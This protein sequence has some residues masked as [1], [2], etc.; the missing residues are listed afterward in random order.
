MMDLINSGVVKAIS[1]IRLFPYSD[2]PSALRFMR[3]AN[4]IGKIIISN[5]EY[6]ELDPMVPVRPAS[7]QFKLRDDVSYLIIGGL[8]GLCGSLAID[9]ARNGARHLIIMSRS[10]YEDPR[11][12]AALKDINAHGCTAQTVRGDVSK[13]EDVRRAFRG[14]SKPVAGVVQGAMVLRDKPFEM[15]SHEEYRTAITPKVAGTWNLHNVALEMGLTLDFFTMLSSISGLI[16]QPAQANYAAANVFLDNFA[17][18]RRGLGLK[19]NSVDLGAIDDIGY[20]AEHSE[21]IAGLDTSAWTPINESLFQ[22]IVQYSIMQQEDMPINSKSF[23]Q[24]ITSIAVPQASSSRLLVD[25]RFSSLL[26]GAAVGAGAGPD[27]TGLNH[28][29]QALLVMIKGGADIV[30]ALPLAVEVANKQFMTS[31]RLD[32]PLEPGKPLSAYGLDSLAAVEFRN[33]SRA[34]LGAELTTLEVTSA[35]SL[36]SLAEKIV[37]KLHAAN[38]AA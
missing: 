31:L 20:M 6:I 10:N 32:E 2:I 21:L 17:Y 1:P 35:P 38:A 23:S 22:N 15:M 28:E 4:H 5:K 8:K 34:Q 18:Y 26:F 3:S 29:I 16:G 37:T 36:L 9:M 19:A 24:L 33:W 27:S 11:S 25:A 14:A 30:T 7:R 13:I 12:Q